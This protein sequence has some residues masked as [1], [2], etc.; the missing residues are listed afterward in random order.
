MINRDI[1]EER[2]KEKKKAHWEEFC[3]NPVSDG[4]IH[5]LLDD[6]LPCRPEE[7]FS[8]PPPRKECKDLGRRKHGR[9]KNLR[10]FFE[11][12]AR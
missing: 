1:K 2:K 11:M 9:W 4:G 7:K 10:K 5:R 6:R 12:Y 3:G 8:Q